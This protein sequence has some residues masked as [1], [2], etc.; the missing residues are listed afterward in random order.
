MDPFALSLILIAAVVHAT[1][2]AIAKSVTGNRYTFVWAYLT[3]A[4]LILMPITAV[5]L[6]EQGWPADTRLVFI[7]MVSGLLH[8]TYLL[9]LQTAYGKG[10]LGVVYPTARGVGPMLTVFVALVFI[11]ERP[12]ALALAGALV[13]LAGILFVAASSATREQWLS[14]G[15]LWG[16]ATGV[17]ISTYTLWDNRAITVWNLDPLPYF[18]LALTTQAVLLTPYALRQKEKHLKQNWWRII[19][20][21]VMWPLGYIL[22]LTAQKTVP[23]S[24]VAPVREMSIIIGAFIGWL[25]YHEEKPLK[26]ILGAGVVLCGIVLLTR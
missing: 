14:K 11:G 18:T 20:L 9:T 2:N 24:I 1:W 3:V 13:V 26:R 19:A 6:Y 7:P 8:L 4:S 17:A 10:D 21:A 25:I 15:V 5:F 22:I 12:P 23:I 16:A